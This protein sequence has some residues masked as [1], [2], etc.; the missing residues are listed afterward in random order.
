M[1]MDISQ[2]Y[3]TIGMELK[4]RLSTHDPAK[5]KNIWAPKKW[6]ESERNLREVVEE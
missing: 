1:P 3:A 2:T 4:I 6:E 5:W